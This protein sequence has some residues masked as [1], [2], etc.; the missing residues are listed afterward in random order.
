MDL[1]Q[2]HAL[3]ERFRKATIG[4]AV[5]VE[6]NVN[7]TDQFAYEYQDQSLKT[8]V[9]LKLVRATQG[10]TA[11]YVLAR[12][13]FFVDSGAAGR[14][15]YE[16]L[17]EVYFMLEEYPKQ[18]QTVDQFIKHYFE[19]TL[20][21]HQRRKTPSVPT[22]KVRA[23]WV[24]FMKKRQDDETQRQLESIYDGF[25][26]YIH[27]NYVHSMEI[28]NGKN[29]TFS[30]AGVKDQGAIYQKMENVWGAAEAVLLAV[31]ISA[32]ILGMAEFKQEAIKI[33]DEWEIVLNA[34]DNG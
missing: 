26:G 14:C 8:V 29:H 25:S 32:H 28:Y 6:C 17:Q 19:G 4:N 24:R 18:S 31:G 13:G 7:G 2:L 22:K 10:V 27:A 23:A 5:R 9:V 12:D 21:G 30:L 1:N 11:M 20:L 34:P 16:A 15:V 3:V 33:A